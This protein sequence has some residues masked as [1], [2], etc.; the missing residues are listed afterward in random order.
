MTR[1]ARRAAE[2]VHDRNQ[3]VEHVVESVLVE[4]PALSKYSQG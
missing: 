2:L 4:L 1:P 3:L